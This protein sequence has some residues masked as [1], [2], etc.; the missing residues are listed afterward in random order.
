MSTTHDDIFSEPGTMPFDRIVVR[1]L[2]LADLDRVV[3]IDAHAVG[4]SRREY[5]SRK[6]TEV[7]TDS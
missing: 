1:D 7:V 4:R 2:G 5:Y 6:L 3:R